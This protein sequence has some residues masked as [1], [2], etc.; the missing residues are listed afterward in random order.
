MDNIIK[1]MDEDQIENDIQS[2]DIRSEHDKVQ[3]PETVQKDTICKYLD[4]LV[5]NLGLD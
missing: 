2:E 4:P 1:L 5:E 3:I